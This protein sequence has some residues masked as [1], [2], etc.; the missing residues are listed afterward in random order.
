M[1]R[2]RIALTFWLLGLLFAQSFNISTTNNASVLISPRSVMFEPPFKD[3][4]RRE[5]EHLRFILERKNSF[6]A[7]KKVINMSG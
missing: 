2:S 5:E 3:K 4:F 1:H 7:K 6:L